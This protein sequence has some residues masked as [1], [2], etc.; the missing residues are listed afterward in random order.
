MKKDCYTRRGIYPVAIMKY[1]PKLLHISKLF[2]VY[3]AEKIECI[4][5]A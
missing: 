4:R 2:E 1:I 3:F 5:S